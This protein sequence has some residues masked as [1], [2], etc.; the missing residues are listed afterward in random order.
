MPPNS[1]NSAATVTTPETL[2]E[3][4]I[5]VAS[6]LHTHPGIPVFLAC[7]DDMPDPEIPGTTLVR[8]PLVAPESVKARNAFHRSDA[9]L[10]KMA[11]MRAAFA[12]GHANCFFFDADL[13][14]LEAVRLP[15]PADD[16]EVRLSLNLSEMDADMKVSAMVTGLFN[17]GFLWTNNPGF[18]GWW[19]EQYL[20]PQPNDFYEQS[21]L[22]R[23]HKEFRIGYFPPEH[24]Y[25]WWR[26]AVGKR[27]VSSFHCHMT[28]DLP[29]FNAGMR[30]HTL[31]LRSEVLRRAPHE[32]LSEVRDAAGHV[33][34]LFFVHYHKTAGVYTSR[35][36]KELSMG[37]YRLD[38]W[39]RPYELG[40]DWTPEELDA[41]LRTP[42]D[43]E[44]YYLHQ[45]HYNVT[46]DD[47]VTAQE[48]GWTTVMFYRDPR[49][50]ISSLYHFVKPRDPSVG[51]FDEFFAETIEQPNLWALP[52]WHVLLDY[53]LPFSEKNLDLVCERLFKAPHLPDKKINQ[54][55]NP[56]W[57]KVFSAE[58]AARILNHPEFT[59]SMSWLS[60]QP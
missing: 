45:H 49:E 53:C 20:N 4:R 25:G 12:A 52:R 26:G 28:D 42:D 56:G 19:E 33:K 11:A 7:P 6:F 32:V 39:S 24:N 59:R 9:I 18:P 27:K 38:S 37:Y 43:G 1:L 15:V 14:F 44:R 54:S 22:S 30:S 57:E 13:V 46:A 36:F 51:S 50:I 17:A 41:H 31:S 58:Q 34:R 48:N 8:R 40:R 10:L 3:A 29:N 16:C 5:A 23:A 21:C 60:K 47:L 2:S 55:D 35:A